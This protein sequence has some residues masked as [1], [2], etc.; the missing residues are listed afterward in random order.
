MLQLHP[1]F[2]FC[3][4]QTLKPASRRG[5]HISVQALRESIDFMDLYL[6]DSC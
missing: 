2:D 5:N 6:P 3:S 1:H 4:I